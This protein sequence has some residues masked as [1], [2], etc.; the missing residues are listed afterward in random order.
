MEPSGGFT[1][2]LLSHSPP[3]PLP[4]TWLYCS[5]DMALGGFNQFPL[6]SGAKSPSFEDAHSHFSQAGSQAIS[7]NL[8]QPVRQGRTR[9]PALLSVST[10][11]TASVK[12]KVGKQLKTRRSRAGSSKC[13]VR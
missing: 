4:I 7:A 12:R 8:L 2:A 9:F 10:Y 6:L 5:F 11:W 3:N 13:Q 1:V